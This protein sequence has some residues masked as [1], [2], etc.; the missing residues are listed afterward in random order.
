M[1][2]DVRLRHLADM[3]RL[4]QLVRNAPP[5]RTCEVLLLK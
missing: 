3:H 2:R 5:K 1:S 4:T